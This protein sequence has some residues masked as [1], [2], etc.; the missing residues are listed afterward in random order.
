MRQNIV[1]IRWI[2][3]YMEEFEASEVRF[4]GTTLWM[5]LTAGP[6]RIIPLTQVR[7]FGQTTE[8]HQSC[9]Y[10]DGCKLYLEGQCIIPIYNGSSQ[11]ECFEKHGKEGKV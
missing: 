2:D 4:S 6:E 10:Q 11:Q 8:S 9:E 3:G 7:W 5:R 1:T